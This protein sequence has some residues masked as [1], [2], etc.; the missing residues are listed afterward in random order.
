MRTLSLKVPEHLDGELAREVCR[1][2]VTKSEL[3]RLALEAYLAPGR[4]T[5]GRSFAA[6]AGD[7]SGCLEGP[8][9]LSWA[10]RH[11]EGYGE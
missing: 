1:L 11:M 8:A 2:R 7:L 4:E 9:D 10:E 3:V 5:D 6:R